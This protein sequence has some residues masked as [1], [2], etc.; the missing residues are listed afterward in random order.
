MLAEVYLGKRGRL[1][2]I[3]SIKAISLTKKTDQKIGK[4]L[5]F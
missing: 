3:A 5:G 4:L 1:N 2:P